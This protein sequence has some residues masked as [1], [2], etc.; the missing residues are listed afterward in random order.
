MPKRAKRSAGESGGHDVRLSKKL[1][2][3][4]RHRVHEN[5]LGDVLRPDGSAKQK[6]GNFSGPGET[7][8]VNVY[9][10]VTIPRAHGARGG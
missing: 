5:G 9:L 2:N 8:F 10:L 6:P 4:L 1:S 7:V 3:V